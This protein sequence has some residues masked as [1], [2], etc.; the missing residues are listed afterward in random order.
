MPKVCDSSTVMTPSLPTLS[1]ASA[2]MSPISG[3]AAEMD[4]TWE[5]CSFDSVSLA[6]ALSDAVAASTPASMPL[7]ERHRVGPGGHVA[8]ALVDHG[9][10]ENGGGGGPVT[11]DVVGLLRDLFDELG[12][13]LL[14]GVFEIDLLGDRDTVVGDRGGAPLLLENDVATL[15]PE[16]HPDRIGQL[17]HPVL[18]GPPGLLVEGDQLGH[19]WFLRTSRSWPVPQGALPGRSRAPLP[20]P[21]PYRL[22][23]SVSTLYVRVPSVSTLYVRVLT[24]NHHTVRAA[25]AER[26]LR[27]AGTQ[28]PATAGTIEM[29]WPSATG[30]PRPWRKRTSSSARKTLTKRRRLPF[31]SKS[32]SAKPGMGGVEGLQVP[33]RRSNLRAAAR[34]RHRTRG[35]SWDGIRTVALTGTDSE[36]RSGR[37][38]VHGRR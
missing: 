13:D 24:A 3:S 16:G 23:C 6:I 33:R 14:P 32:R 25:T 21:A 5:I 36:T 35:R 8:Q 19:S 11:G 31:S 34:R 26:D 30:V 15:R 29:V 27:R 37:V 17:V 20:R 22:A 38:E 18:E 10:G 9:P 2:I 1:I 28:P 12:P 7:L 4:A